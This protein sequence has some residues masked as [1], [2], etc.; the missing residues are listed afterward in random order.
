MDGVLELGQKLL[1]EV[2]LELLVVVM[3][4][5]AVVVGADVSTAGI[6]TG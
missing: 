3:T 6:E 2:E 5:T 1:T 4:P